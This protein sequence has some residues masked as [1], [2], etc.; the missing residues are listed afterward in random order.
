MS[1]I[2]THLTTTF[3]PCALSPWWKHTCG[4]WHQIFNG[5][6]SNLWHPSCRHRHLSLRLPPG[7]LENFAIC[8][9]RG[10]SR[11]RSSNLRS[12]FKIITLAKKKH[13]TLDGS[14]CKEGNFLSRKHNP[15]DEK[16]ENMG[17]RWINPEERRQ[18]RSILGYNLCISHLSVQFTQRGW[19]TKFIF[20]FTQNCI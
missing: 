15:Q 13:S 1:F 9:T 16:S 2:S 5:Q 14:K 19:G 6:I 4:P 3:S 20:N 10:G 11:W 7:P 12:E 17:N 18:I 8:E